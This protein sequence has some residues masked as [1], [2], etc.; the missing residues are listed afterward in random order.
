MIREEHK[1]S[2]ICLR[3]SRV[4]DKATLLPD[5]L[6]IIINGMKKYLTKVRTCI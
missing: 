6:G 1:N 4:Y 3:E 5:L 2:E